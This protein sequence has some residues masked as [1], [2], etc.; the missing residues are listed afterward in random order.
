LYWLLITIAAVAGVMLIVAA[1]RMGPGPISTHPTIPI[2]PPRTAPTVQPYRPLQEADLFF[3]RAMRAYESGDSAQA[4]FAGRI[5]LE[6][7]AML[8]GLDPD[9][10]FHI[11]LL[12]QI[13]GDLNAMLAQAD[14]IE[15]TFPTHLFA[16]LLRY[17]VYLADGDS[18]KAQA[19]VSQFT[20]RYDMEM[21]QAR[22]E[23]EL[24]ENLIERF[25]ADALRLGPG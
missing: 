25:K 19:A 16:A 5:A 11:G 4:A 17:R 12:H 6:A 2:L 9:A 24:H 18:E 23:Y 7:Y 3:D 22:P 1:L 13:S 15:T 20:Q 21:A 14:S 8:D 10:R